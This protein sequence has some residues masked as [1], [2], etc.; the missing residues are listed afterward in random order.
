MFTIDTFPSW[1]QVCYSFSRRDDNSSGHPCIV[2][3]FAFWHF[4]PLSFASSSNFWDTLHYRYW[5]KYTWLARNWDRGNDED[6]TISRHISYLMAVGYWHSSIPAFERILGSWK[7][8]PV[9]K[10]KCRPTSRLYLCSEPRCPRSFLVIRFKP[11]AYGTRI[12]NINIEALWQTWTTPF[13]VT[14]SPFHI[15]GRKAVQNESQIYQQSTTAKMLRFQKGQHTRT[16]NFA[17][18]VV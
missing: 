9:T 15:D 3:T 8:W 11:F 1:V 4:C 6:A 18:Q 2:S 10:C 7:T 5:S 14:I 16:S 17:W 13:R 12:D